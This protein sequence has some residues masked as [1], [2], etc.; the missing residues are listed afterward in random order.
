MRFI[1]RKPQCL[2]NLQYAQKANAVP[3]VI[4][5]SR[6]VT[7]SLWSWKRLV[8][9]PVVPIPQRNI[10]LISRSHSLY[11]LLV[12][13]SIQHPLHQR[14]SGHFTILVSRRMLTHPA[15]IW[16]W[17]IHF[18]LKVKGFLD[19]EFKVLDPRQH[20]LTS[21]QPWQLWLLC[22]FIT[23]GQKPH[24]SGSLVGIY[25]LFLEMGSLRRNS[26]IHWMSLKIY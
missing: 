8:S 7:C 17:W 22:W 26:I 21:N 16:G 25:S 15:K 1:N 19:W 10:D 11:F 3:I 6:R 13:L 14:V 9:Q 4:T 5:G 24:I 18:I 23:H 12:A 20:S 2:F